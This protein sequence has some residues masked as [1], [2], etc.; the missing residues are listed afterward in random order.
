MSSSFCMH[1]ISLMKTFW[2]SCTAV[3]SCQD[4]I[5]AILSC[6]TLQSPAFRSCNVFS[7]LLP[8]LF[9]MVPR[10]TVHTTTASAPLAAGLT[11]DHILLRQ[12]HW[13]PVWQWITYKL[14]VLMF[15]ILYTA[16]SAYLSRLII[17]SVSGHTAHSSSSAAVHSIT[18]AHSLWMRFLLYYY[19][20]LEFSAK[21]CDCDSCWL[22]GNWQI[23]A[24]LTCLI[25]HLGDWTMQN[26]L[27]ISIQ[28]FYWITA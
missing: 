14:S 5:T 15:K 26:V 18:Q 8:P 4:S 16:T 19:H 24:R 21:H 25:R 27:Q 10:S 17:A 23:E 13:L 6:T 20:H 3:S 9:C 1:V 22:T 11:V 28:R 12:L 2:T 7:A